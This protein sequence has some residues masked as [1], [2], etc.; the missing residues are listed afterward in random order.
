MESSAVFSQ[1]IAAGLYS[2]LIDEIGDIDESIQNLIKSAS[3]AKVG[4][5]RLTDKG[6]KRDNP[7]Q[8]RTPVGTCNEL[9]DWMR[10]T[11]IIDRGIY[12]HYTRFPTNQEAWEEQQKA[13]DATPGNV[14]SFIVHAFDGKYDK[15]SWRSREEQ[16]ICVRS[17]QSRRIGNAGKGRGRINRHSIPRR[18]PAISHREKVCHGLLAGGR[19]G[20]RPK[21]AIFTIFGM[22][23]ARDLLGL[24]YPPELEVAVMNY[25]RI[26]ASEVLIEKVSQIWTIL[27]TYA[28]N[29]EELVKTEKLIRKLEL[30]L[31]HG[32]FDE[33]ETQEKLE[34]QKM[35]AERYSKQLQNSPFV[36]VTR[37]KDKREWFAITTDALKG[38]QRAGIPANSL[39]ELEQLCD[40]C[41][42]TYEAYGTKKNGDKYRITVNIM[43]KTQRCIHILRESNVGLLA[44]DELPPDPLIENSVKL[45][46]QVFQTIHVAKTGPQCNQ[47]PRNPINTREI[48]ID[49]LKTHLKAGKKGVQEIEVDQCIKELMAAGTLTAPGEGRLTRVDLDQVMAQ[50]GHSSRSRVLKVFEVLQDMEED[51]GGN[52]IEQEVLK[53]PLTLR[54]GN[55]Q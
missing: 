55:D 8:L 19:E 18:R 45:G 48:R 3:T 39:T 21:K 36:R 49:A 26:S 46:G 29:Y 9:T 4:R 24:D 32:E 41:G 27:A 28:R 30:R 37:R 14:F 15:D 11:A 13:Y 5:K 1:V 12:C 23:L 7:Q 22:R 10:K 53:E 38:M 51:N 6:K 43:G 2:L 35:Q 54:R 50:G 40:I 52:P 44:N 17:P 16:Q 31:H 25:I 20:P 47:V 42:I 33:W 34:N